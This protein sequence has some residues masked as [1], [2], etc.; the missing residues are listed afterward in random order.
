MYCPPLEN[1]R[2]H[3]CVRY[4]LPIIARCRDVGFVKSGRG[5]FGSGVA[6]AVSHECWGDRR[7]TG[8]WI[9]DGNNNGLRTIELSI[10]IA[11][12]PDCGIGNKTL[13]TSVEIPSSSLGTINAFRRN[14]EPHAIRSVLDTNLD[15]SPPPPFDPEDIHRVVYY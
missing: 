2:G 14:F 8:D 10:S 5:P 15:S 3:P 13:S 4:T 7:S 9:A 1:S 6:T 11:F 12:T